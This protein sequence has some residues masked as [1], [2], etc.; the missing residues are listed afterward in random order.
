L[1]GGSEKKCLLL[2]A[3]YIADPLRMLTAAQVI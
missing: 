2:L 1:E 3:V